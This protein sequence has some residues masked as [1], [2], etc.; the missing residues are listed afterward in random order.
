ML[1]G[2]SKFG[3][4]LR[5]YIPH[6]VPHIVNV[7][8]DPKYVSVIVPYIASE[9]SRQKDMKAKRMNSQGLRI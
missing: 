4:P 9:Q 2:L 1:G 8:K 3:S 5:I 6:I 7:N